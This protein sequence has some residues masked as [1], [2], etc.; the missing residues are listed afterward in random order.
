MGG[1]STE[2]GLLAVLIL[3][4][5][6]LAAGLLSLVIR[7]ARLLHAV[8]LSTMVALVV[9]ETALTSRILAEGPMTALGDLVYVDALSAFI[10]FI[11]TAIGLSC[12]LY[13]WSYM[14]DQVARGVIS[15]KRLSR[16]FFLFHMFLLAMVAATTA[17]S[18]G[19]Q[20]VAVEGTTLATTFLI[21]FFRRRESLEAGWKYLILCSVGIA[22]ALFGVV[23]TYYSSVRVLGDVSAALNITALVGVADRLDPNVLKLAFI[24]ILVGY[25]TKVGLVPMHTWLPEAYSEA[26]APVAAMLAGVLETVAVYAVLRSKTIVDQALPPEFSGNLLMFF[27]FVSF[28]VASLF[29]LIQHNYKRLFAYSSIEHMGLAMVGFGVGGPAGTFGGLFHLLNHALAKALAFF[30]AG[31]IHRR[32]GTLEIDGVHGLASSQPI[33]AVVLLVAGFALVGL[34]PFSPFASELLVISAMAAQKFPS[35]SIQVGNFLTLAIPDEV[36]S[37][38]IVALFMVFALVL[39]GGFAYR[40][41]TMVWGVPSEHTPRGEPWTLG[42][43]PLIAMTAALIGLGLMLPEPVRLLLSEA[44]AVVSGR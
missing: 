27:G 28:A 3:L 40:I 37:L 14:D 12:S 44:V 32:F 25:G 1:A 15:P 38:G 24:F 13:M 30:A 18:L 16:F 41:G 35:G 36:R 34:P 5:W 26:P 11:I 42:H 10:L 7:R 2:D 33:T 19:V 8:N 6:P 31:N 20:W 29:I 4:V 9:A 22:L 17:N 43:V 21:A 23:L 39:F